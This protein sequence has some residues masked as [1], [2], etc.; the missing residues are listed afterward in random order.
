MDLTCP[1]LGL[2]EQVHSQLHPCIRDVWIC[3]GPGRGEWKHRTVSCTQPPIRGQST[4]ASLGRCMLARN[5][6]GKFANGERLSSL[7]QSAH[8]VGQDKDKIVEGHP[9]HTT[10]RPAGGAGQGWGRTT[11][12][13][14]RWGGTRPG[15]AQPRY[16]VRP[17]LC[18]GGLAPDPSTVSRR[19][20]VHCWGPAQNGP[21]TTT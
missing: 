14:P 7:Q 19:N 8:C 9:A 16:T 6:R 1:P 21:E 20:C 11:R 15:E 12:R 3:W 5:N 10:L 18:I 13:G 2:G 17:E 4:E